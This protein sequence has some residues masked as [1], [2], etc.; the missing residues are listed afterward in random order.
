MKYC[1]T[2]CCTLL[3]LTAFGQEKPFRFALLA[4]P[5]VSNI[6]Q[7]SS[8][9]MVF[10]DWNENKVGYQV[11]LLAEHSLAPRIAARM[12]VGYVN[13]GSRLPKISVDFAM[14][15]PIALDAVQINY[16]YTDLLLPMHLRFDLDR[17]HHWFVTTGLTPSFKIARKTRFHQWYLDGR[18]EIHTVKNQDS[19]FRELNANFHLGFGYALHLRGAWRLLFQPGIDFNLAGQAM[20]V[21]QNERV[22]AAGLNVGLMW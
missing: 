2:F 15:D 10:G 16:I 4:G 18:D 8:G 5:N 3:V 11:C 13:T 9:N 21:P 1:Y 19:N 14:P 7:S 22:F 20:D 17:G 12:G 6:I